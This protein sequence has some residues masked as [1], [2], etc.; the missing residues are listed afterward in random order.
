VVIY[1]PF[2]GLLWGLARENHKAEWFPHVVTVPAALLD[3]DDAH[4]R[5]GRV[6]QVQL[7]GVHSLPDRQMIGALLLEHAPLKIIP[8]K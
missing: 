1:D 4:N 3:V 8:N 7:H 2:V 5:V 6:D